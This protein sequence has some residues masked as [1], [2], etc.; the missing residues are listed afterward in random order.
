M[1]KFVGAV[2]LRCSSDN[3]EDSFVLRKFHEQ[4]MREVLKLNKNVLGENA[5]IE[6]WEIETRGG[7]ISNF[8]N[9]LKNLIKLI[10]DGLIHFVLIEKL[11]RLSRDSACMVNFKKILKERSCTLYVIN[12]G[13][14]ILF[15]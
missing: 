8:S 15:E 3:D 11:D 4:R 10:E 1:S 13:K 14:V 12:N 5:V 2:Y 6:H 7:Y 9:S